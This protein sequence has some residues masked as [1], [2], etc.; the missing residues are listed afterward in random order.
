MS[1]R[2]GLAFRG[3]QDREACGWLPSS[4]VLLDPLFRCPPRLPANIRA[5]A[6]FPSFSFRTLYSSLARSR[7]EFLTIV[8]V[9]TIWVNWVVV[10]QHPVAR[11]SE[12]LPPFCVYFLLLFSSF[13]GLLVTVV[14]LR[15]SWAA[16]D[17]EEKTPTMCTS[18]RGTAGLRETR[19]VSA[20]SVRCLCA[21]SSFG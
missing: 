20:R 7:G 14:A 18:V 13:L 10:H 11:D 2:G 6:L 3:V 16:G 15:P 17:A 21:C 19:P 8:L 4:S 1:A 5:R 12:R 9:G